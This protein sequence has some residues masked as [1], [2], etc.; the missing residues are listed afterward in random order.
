MARLLHQSVEDARPCP[1]LPGIDASLE[2][3]VLLDVAPHEA[4]E[5]LDRG[6]RHFGP[7]W[8]RPA[9]KTCKACLSTRILAAE[10]APS[11]SQRRVARRTRHLRLEIREPIFDR[12]R[13]ALF[14]AWQR[15][16][17]ETRGW[18]T[19]PFGAKDYWMRFT[20]SSPFARELAYYDDG[21]DGR[22][23][24][25]SICDET[26]RAWSAVFCFYDPAYHRLSLGIANILNLLDLARTRGQ[27]HVYLGYCVLECQS[28][29]YKAAFRPQETLVGLPGDDETPRWARDHFIAE[30]SPRLVAGL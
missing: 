20:F 30:D 22:L 19:G 26:P 21:A 7:G 23:V 3:R 12:T 8:F 6:W 16:R 1:Y 5:L 17:V 4:D 24:M 25:V 18:E 10:F 28:L 11:K 29:R 13:L 27:R 15:D 2:H 9:C 14:H